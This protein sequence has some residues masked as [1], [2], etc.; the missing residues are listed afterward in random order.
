MVVSAQISRLDPRD[1]PR[2]ADPVLR[3]TGHI[4]SDESARLPRVLSTGESA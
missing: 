2:L 4:I 3:G 1:T